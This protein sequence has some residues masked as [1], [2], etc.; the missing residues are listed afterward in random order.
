MKEEARL[1]GKRWRAER[2]KGTEWR[3]LVER[4]RMSCPYFGTVGKNVR[5]VREFYLI[6]FFF[7]RKLYSREME[8]HRNS[9]AQ[10]LRM[11]LMF[12]VKREIRT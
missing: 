8:R 3:G 7:I 2:W 6:Y 5:T 11:I 10:S 12:D 9:C 1:A 4:D